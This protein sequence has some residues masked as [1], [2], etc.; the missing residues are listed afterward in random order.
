MLLSMWRQ[1]IPSFIEVL[2]EAQYFYVITLQK[3][4]CP[5]EI[6]SV[7]V[8]VSFGESPFLTLLCWFWLKQG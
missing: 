3:S 1:C 2:R 8:S 7:C 4:L 6:P 5:Y